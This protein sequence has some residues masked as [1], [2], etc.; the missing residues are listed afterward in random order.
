MC[1]CKFDAAFSKR[2]KW[3]SNIETSS[4]TFIFKETGQIDDRI[5]MIVSFL[6]WHRYVCPHWIFTILPFSHSKCISRNLFHAM[7]ALIIAGLKISLIIKWYVAWEKQTIWMIS[8]NWIHLTK[9]TWAANFNTG[10]LVICQHNRR[11][12]ATTTK[13]KLMELSQ[14]EKKQRITKFQ[15][16]G[17]TS[18]TK[19]KNQ[20]TSKAIVNFYLF[21]V[22]RIV[23][24]CVNKSNLFMPFYTNHLPLI[25]FDLVYRTQTNSTQKK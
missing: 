14:T 18:P 8:K 3:W 19:T 1:A 12:D 5:Q 17:E 9:S 13:L 4:S 20:F 7:L 11:T 24:F 16:V 23:N 2:R 22:L 15:L 6:F 25:G 10:F 21:A